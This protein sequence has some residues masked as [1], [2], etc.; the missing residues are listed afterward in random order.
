MRLRIRTRIRLFTLMRG[1]IRIQIL[2]SKLRLKPLKKCSKYAHIPFVLACHLQND[3][4]PDPPYHCDADPDVD[5]DPDF[6]LMQMRIR[7]PKMMQIQAD[8][9]P[10][11][12]HWRAWL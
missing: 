12:Q 5:P 4:D 6:Y 11:H 2:A 9:D 1:R 10:A 3:A 7:V 8:P